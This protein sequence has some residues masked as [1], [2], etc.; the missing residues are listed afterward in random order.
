MV[1]LVQRSIKKEKRNPVLTVQ[2]SKY[3]YALYNQIETLLCVNRQI[4][5]VGEKEYKREKE[6]EK[7]RER[8]GE[9]RK[10]H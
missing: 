1:K 7:E 4:I 3:T 2:V 8:E 9:R 6:G 5:P 10:K